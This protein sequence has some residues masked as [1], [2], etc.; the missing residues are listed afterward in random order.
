[1][2]IK[3]RHILCAI[4]V[5]TLLSDIIISVFPGSV[6]RI[7]LGL[8]LVLFFPGYTLI[9]AIFPDKHTIL[10]LE[11]IALSFGV[12]I[13]MVALV[14]LIIS[15]SPWGIGLYSIL[16][17]L[18]VFVLVF[19]AVAWA[20]QVRL[21]DKEIPVIR[22][23]FKRT[24]FSGF[25]R[26]EKVLAIVLAVVLITAIGTI[27]FVVT[28]PRTGDRFTEFYVLDTSGKT[29][30]YPSELQLGEKGEVVVGVVNHEHETMSYA[31]E[32][33]MEGITSAG[34]KE[35]TLAGEEK[36]E[37]AV[38]FTT[39]RAGDKQKVEFLLYITGQDEPYQDLYLW[40]NV[41]PW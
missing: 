11:K 22:V 29:V 17:S 19:S 31:L 14:G 16:V 13:A 6:L 23:N 10:R 12:S 40:V 33:R 8:P 3:P 9:C 37:N 28:A 30:D 21:P 4:V 20:R 38:S 24:L 7:I 26:T 2:Q 18:S 1:M 15:F 36:W 35:I 25:N 32:V 27:T 39:A 5:L 34:R 41:K